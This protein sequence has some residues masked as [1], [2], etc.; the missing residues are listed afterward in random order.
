[1]MI[2]FQTP[3]SLQAIRRRFQFDTKEEA[4]QHYKQKKDLFGLWDERTLRAYI[5]GGTK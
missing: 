3:L 2:V 1:M 5:E 4:Y